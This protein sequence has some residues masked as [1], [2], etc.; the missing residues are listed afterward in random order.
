MKNNKMNTMRILKNEM[1]MMRFLINEMNDFVKMQ[2]EL[3]D[4][5]EVEV[6]AVS[7]KENWIT[8]TLVLEDDM[9]YGRTKRLVKTVTI[10]WDGDNDFTY[11]VKTVKGETFYRVDGMEVNVEPIRE[12]C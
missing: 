3:W 12:L 9:A 2:G 4:C 1:N 7:V 5:Y 8:G 10:R 11:H 6:E